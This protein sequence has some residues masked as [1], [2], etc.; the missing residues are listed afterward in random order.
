[1]VWFKPGDNSNRRSCAAGHNIVVP[2]TTVKSDGED[3]TMIDQMEER[4]NGLSVPDSR[5][6]CDHT[7][8][9]TI[10]H[11]DDGDLENPYNWS[12]VSPD[13]SCT[14]NHRKLTF[15]G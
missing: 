8:Q 10:I 4:E 11:W 2:Q 7:T 5:V 14:P 1:M 12:T 13:K 6:S 9:K 15:L 3:A